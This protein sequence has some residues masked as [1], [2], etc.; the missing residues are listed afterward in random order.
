[1]I[2]VGLI[3]CGDVAEH[4]HVPALLRH[5]K[6]RLAAVCDLI[7][8]RAH[9]L[10]MRA[11]DAPLH[12]DW[13][14]MLKSH[15]LDAVV[16]ALPPELSPEVV[17]ACLQ[18]GLAVLDEKPLAATLAQGRALARLVV[19]RKSIYQ[20][21]FVL[22]Y[23]DWVR[24]IT[25]LAGTIGSPLTTKVE[26]Y[27]ELWD[28]NN[29]AHFNRIQGF[30]KNCSAL[31]HEGS[32][33]IDYTGLWISSPWKR[34][35]AFA[36]QTFP[37]FAGPNIW[38]AQVDFDDLSTLSVKIGWLLPELPPS[39]IEVKGSAGRIFFNCRTGFGEYEVETERR[40]LSL[41]PLAAEWDRQYDA[42]AAAIESGTVDCARVQDGLVALEVTT[43]CELSARSGAAITKL[44]FQS[45]FGPCEII[46][47]PE[48]PTSVDRMLT[49]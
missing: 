13:R 17:S 43:A 24:E 46:P 40:A 25:R 29:S 21:G 32:H 4:G 15:P 18:Q 3:G 48:A 20:S 36:Q 9:L 47:H 1:M 49:A 45:Q 19:E 27:D 16:V 2:A 26:V 39:T 8:E 31:T 34:V 7:P 38:N 5:P 10:S 12:S 41:A 37:T 33:V 28:P 6:F 35:T 30:L 11:N 22:R 44:E 14:V 23:G 42:F